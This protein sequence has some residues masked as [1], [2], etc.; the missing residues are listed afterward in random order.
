MRM[1][2]SGARVSSLFLNGS[3]FGTIDEYCELEES[4][5]PV[6]TQFGTDSKDGKW[7]QHG[8]WIYTHFS[9]AHNIHHVV[10]INKSHGI[11]GFDTHKGEFTTDVEPYTEDRSSVGNALRVFG[12]TMHVIIHGAK[13]HNISHLR[14]S[15]ANEDLGHI[16]NKVVKNK[17]FNKH[18]ENAGF[19]YKEQNKKYHVFER[20]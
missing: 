6:H 16:Y 3:Y 20:I 8:D 9:S 12:K 13:H 14:F 4:V 15:A 10:S 19:R 11:V 7:N 1:A 18:L 2:I 5:Q 17:Y